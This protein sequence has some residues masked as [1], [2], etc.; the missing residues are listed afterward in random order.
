MNG[1][2]FACGVQETQKLRCLSL[3]SGIGGLELG[4]RPPESQALLFF[5]MFMS[6]GLV[7]RINLRFSLPRE[8]ELNSQV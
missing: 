8:P 2:L 4:V 5:A 1:K 7:K 3:F 6:S